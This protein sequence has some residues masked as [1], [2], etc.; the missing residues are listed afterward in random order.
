[1]TRGELPTGTVTFLF[2]DIEGSTRLI[3]ALGERWKTILEDHNRLLRSAVR[4][5][6]GIDI[7]TQGDALFAVF[8]SARRPWA[9]RRRRSAP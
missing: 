6:G 1:V 9:A 3:Q 8:R 7:R 5:A 4:K 2:T